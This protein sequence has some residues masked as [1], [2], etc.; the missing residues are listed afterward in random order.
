MQRL[1]HSTR[2]YIWNAD[3]LQTFLVKIDLM[4]TLE[5]AEENGTLAKITKY[6]SID[7]AEL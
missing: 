6:H 4:E 3:G 2:A 5:C 7:L 1:N